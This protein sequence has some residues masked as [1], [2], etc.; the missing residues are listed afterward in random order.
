M[1][2]SW[3]YGIL[4]FPVVAVTAFL[5]RS[6]S[7]TFITVSSSSGDPNV[8]AGIASFALTVAS[9]WGGILVALVVLGCL[10]ADIRSLGD[11][12]EWSPSLAWSLAGLV[13]L[14]AAVFSPLL[15][16]SI[17]TLTYYLYRR[18]TRLGSP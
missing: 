14:G 15:V 12:G 1:S 6:G 18:H 9:F 5:A 3:W 11:G 4:L 16:V 13:H 2:S 10:F 17:P 8:A 7:R